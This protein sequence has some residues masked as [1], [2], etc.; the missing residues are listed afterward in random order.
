VVLTP[1]ESLTTYIDL[2]GKMG[3]VAVGIGVFLMLLSKPLTRL[4]HGVE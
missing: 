2:F 3:F 1:T 4:M